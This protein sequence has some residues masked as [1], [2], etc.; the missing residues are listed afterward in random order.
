MQ[1]DISIQSIKELHYKL[2]REAT[3]QFNKYIT[4]VQLWPVHI[5]VRVYI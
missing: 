3:M 4:I 2:K 1:I 5:H